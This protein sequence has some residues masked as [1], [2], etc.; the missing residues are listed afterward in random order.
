MNVKIWYL[1]HSGFA[2]ET[3][4]HFLVFDYWRNTPKGSG[5]DVGVIDVAALKDKDVLVFASHQH[6]DH[7]IREILHWHKDI[8]KLRLILS[9]DIPVVENALMI[10]PG[11]TL[12]QPDFTIKTLKSTDEGVAFVLETDGL[13]IYH[14]GDLH[15]WHWEG[16]PA[17]ENQSM[18][19]NYKEQVALLG[20]DPIDLAFVTLDPR[21]EEQY[22]WGFDYLMRT[23]DIRHAVPMHFGNDTSVVARLLRDPVSEGYRDRIIGLTRR[24]ES[25]EIKLTPTPPFSR[26]RSTPHGTRDRRS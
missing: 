24:G 17:E 5:L 10:G 3:P 22:A 11:Q 25:A 1:Y 23:A 8:P 26:Q 13:R 15:W 19:D 16:E 7:F 9:D 2:V 12:S 6:G 4:T 20:A 21:L 18:G 14:A